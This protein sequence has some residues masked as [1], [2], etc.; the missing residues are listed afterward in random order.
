MKWYTNN[1]PKITIP[2]SSRKMSPAHKYNGLHFCPHVLAGVPSK[3]GPQIGLSL[4]P[5]FQLTKLHILCTYAKTIFIVTKI[6]I[7]RN[8]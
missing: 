2:S 3:F 5:H 7:I 1:Q 8:S 4:S 6:E